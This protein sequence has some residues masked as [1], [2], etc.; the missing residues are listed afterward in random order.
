MENCSLVKFIIVVLSF[1]GADGKLFFDTDFH[2]E[3]HLEMRISQRSLIFHPF[4][5]SNVSFVLFDEK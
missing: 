3:N 1:I 5:P 2:V 4:D